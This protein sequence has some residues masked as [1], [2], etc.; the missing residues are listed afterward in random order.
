VSIVNINRLIFTLS[1]I[2]LAVT[3]FLAFEYMQAGPMVCPVTGT[4]CELVRKSEFSKLLGVDLPIFGIAFYLMTAFVSVW[5]TQNYHQK[6]SL[7]RLAASFSAFAF[8][9]YLTFLEAF[10]IKAYCI[11]CVASFIVS[12][13]ILCL[14]VLDFFK[15]KKENE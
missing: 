2:G 8:G 11:W 4:G 1:L 9:V 10:V 5:L 14:C 7:L 13:M 6:I 15:I 3:A 12:I